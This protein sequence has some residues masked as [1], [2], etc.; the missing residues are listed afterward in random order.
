MNYGEQ[1]DGKFNRGVSLPAF[2]DETVRLTLIKIDNRLNGF[3]NAG[4]RL[5]DITANGAPPSLE[6]THDFTIF[7][8]VVLPGQRLLTYFAMNGFNESKP[9]GGHDPNPWEFI[10]RV[11]RINSSGKEVRGENFQ[12]ACHQDQQG[13]LDKVVFGWTLRI[14][15]TKAEQSELTSDEILELQKR[16]PKT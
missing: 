8:G 4:E 14:Y 9:S 5:F 2:S 15:W 12:I 7:D 1:C 13:G 3:K 11:S 16:F 10:W 6:S